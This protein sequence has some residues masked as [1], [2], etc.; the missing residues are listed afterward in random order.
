[1][2]DIAKECRMTFTEV[3]MRHRIAPLW[4]LYSLNF[5]LKVTHFVMLLLKKAHAA[6]TP[7]DMH[8]LARPPL[9]IFQ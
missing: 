5:V 9:A 8:R 3:D 1:M 7:A 2:R 4:M 6:N